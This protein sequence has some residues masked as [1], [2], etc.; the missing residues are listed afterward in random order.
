VRDADPGHD[1]RRVRAVNLIEQCEPCGSFRAG[2]YDV[3]VVHSGFDG[4]QDALCFVAHRHKRR[5]PTLRIVGRPLWS[6][7]L[8]PTFSGFS[9][10]IASARTGGDHKDRPYNVTAEV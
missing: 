10:S 9:L 7:G 4:H 1:P 3:S 2:G 5:P 8:R 6:A